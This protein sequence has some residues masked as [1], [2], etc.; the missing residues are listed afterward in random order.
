MNSYSV[1]Q[2][3]AMFRGRQARARYKNKKVVKDSDGKDMTV[4]EYSDRQVARRNSDKAKRVQKLRSLRE[5]LIKKVR[6]DLKAKDL[7]TRLTALAVALLDHTYE[8][9]G[10]EDSAEEGHFGV[11]G[12]QAKHV[13]FSNGQATIAYIGKSGVKQSKKV[14]DKDA[15]A[16]LKEITKG[17]SGTDPIFVCEDDKGDEVCI[18][19]KEVNAYLPNGITA[20]DLRGLH[21]NQEMLKRLKTIRSQGGQLSKDKKERE[22][23]LKTEFKKALEDAAKA[24]GHEPSTL[25]SQYLVP[26][27]EEAYLKDGT[28]LK[29]LGGANKT[30]KKLQPTGK[31]TWQGGSIYRMRV[32]QDTFVHFT[33]LSRALE[34]AKRKKL[35]MKPPYPKM[36]IDAVNAVSLTYG[37]Y[38]PSVQTTHIKDRTDPIMAVVFQTSV[39]P[40]EGFIEEVTWKRDVPLKNVK[41]I[42]ASKAIAMLRRTPEQITGDDSVTYKTGTK[43]PLE[44]EE[45]QTRKMLRKEPKKKPPRYDL[46]KQRVEED[47]EDTEKP[48]ADNDKDLSKNYKKVAHLY[49]ARE[50]AKSEGAAKKLYEDYREE[51][52]ETK[53]TWQDFYEK[54]E[55]KKPGEE[56]EAEAKKP[57]EGEDTPKAKKPEGKEK[58][59]PEAEEKAKAVAHRKLVKDTV[60]EVK[61]TLSGLEGVSL[62]GPVRKELSSALEAMTPEQVEAFSGSVKEHSGLVRNMPMDGPGAVKNAERA[63]EDLEGFDFGGALD[64]VELAQ[65]V[66]EKAH[67]EA[68]V[69]RDQAKQKGKKRAITDSITA[70]EDHLK[71]VVGDE[72]YRVNRDARDLMR[73]ELQRVDEEKFADFIQSVIEGINERSKENL[74]SKAALQAARDALVDSADNVREMDNPEAKGAAVAEMIHAQRVL[75]RNEQRAKAKTK[76]VKKA[77]SSVAGIFGEEKVPSSVAKPLEEALDKL[78][79][80]QLPD[81][82][83]AVQADRN[84]IQEHIKP[85]PETGEQ[86]FPPGLVAEAADALRAK[87][88]KG[89]VK[90]VAH[91][92]AMAMAAQHLIAD[93][94]ELAGEEVGARTLDHAGT[95]KRGRM[96]YDKYKEMPYEMQV[97]AAKQI[98][99]RLETLDPESSEA[100]ELNRI[101]DGI[102]L[103]ALTGKRRD[104]GKVPQ[105]PGR[106]VNAGFAEMARAMAKDGK[107]DQLLG[108]VEDFYSA[109]GQQAVHSAMQNMSDEALSQSVESIMPHA[110][111][112]LV[113]TEETD[114]VSGE[115]VTKPTLSE[116]KKAILR[117]ALI[118]ISIDQMAVMDRALKARLE[119]AGD[120]RFDDPDYRAEKMKKARKGLGKDWWDKLLAKWLKPEGRAGLSESQVPTS[121]LPG[122]TADILS[123]W[124]FADLA[125]ESLDP[126][127]GMRAELLEAMDEAMTREVGKSTDSHADRAL[128]RFL[129]TQNPQFL[130]SNPEKSEKSASETRSEVFETARGEKEGRFSR[131]SLDTKH[132]TIAG[133]PSVTA[134]SHFSA[135]ERGP[136]MTT[137]LTKEAAV[138]AKKLT[139]L[140]DHVGNAVQAN[141]QLLEAAG[142]PAKIA[143]DFAYRGDLLSDQIDQAFKAAGEQDPEIKKAYTMGTGQG[144]TPGKDDN[145]NA[146][147]PQKF[148]P[149]DIGE[150]DTTPPKTEADEAYMKKNFIQ[151]EFN[152]LRHFQEDGLFSNAK[153]ASQTVASMIH[154]LQGL[155]AALESGE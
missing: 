144:T 39:P 102:T 116:V 37:G 7:K 81:F 115:R 83:E 79:A 15:V 149:A 143:R 78:P 141:V 42:D 104:E 142:I 62:P 100:A 130:R 126:T 85:D 48:G 136:E 122:K 87:D 64:P 72:S 118:D 20:K 35:L 40:Q 112:Y 155:Q 101:L 33:P 30:A 18:T 60:T 84:L 132:L 49:L 75:D 89:S 120:Q 8:R 146:G 105:I 124:K 113:G 32:G 148:D 107:V 11:T 44:K 12:W 34:I 91:Q 110:K 50:L 38:V 31:E 76:A 9:I 3:A 69:K 152:E 90:E 151:E 135:P 129:E 24:V 108:P 127:V 56:D 28:V 68:V 137:P 125:G 16:V 111:Q 94:F 139:D 14:T 147:P 88:Y 74:D 123:V 1:L 96:A 41:V 36:G 26:K 117:N 86:S 82:I 19:G 106:E 58:P 77:I 52:P 92:V 114:E 153:A 45:E 80:D 21:A 10:N 131:F 133:Q 154:K 138:Q 67:A 128:T 23:K 29:S 134:Q 55:D 13:M 43:T 145:T 70:I 6:K 63:L 25:R 119:K 57:A 99:E 59:D 121:G 61:K 2:V 98:T 46:R 47:D 27:L 65:K 51:N 103:A 97:S 22:E 109:E 95:V 140:F 73:N 17:K 54:P 71:E 66:V 93:P 150:Q 4:Y 53:K 5:G